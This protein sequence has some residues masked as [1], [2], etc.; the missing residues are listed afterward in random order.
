MSIFIFSGI[1]FYMYTLILTVINRSNSTFNISTEVVNLNLDNTKYHLFND[2][3]FSF[4]V[5][6]SHQNGTSVQIDESYFN[7][8]IYY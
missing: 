7:L 6:L 5:S 1:G 4:A 8:T 3:G 2:Y